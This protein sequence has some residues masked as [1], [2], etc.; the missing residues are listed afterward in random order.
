MGNNLLREENIMCFKNKS[1]GRGCFWYPWHYENASVLT[2]VIRYIFYRHLRGPSWAW[3][4][5]CRSWIYSYLSNRCRSPLK[6]ASSNPAHGEVFS[7]QHHVIQFVSDLRSSVI[8]SG[9]SVPRYNWNIVESGVTLTPHYWL[10]S[11]CIGDRIG[12]S[13]APEG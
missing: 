6:Y 8:F 1:D 2:W 11:P 9:C 10:S 4:W 5:P 12:F 7:I 13:G 3:V